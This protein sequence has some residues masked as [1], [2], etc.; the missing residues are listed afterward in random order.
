MAGRVA[1]NKEQSRGLASETRVDR[2]VGKSAGTWSECA[3]RP[4][5]RALLPPPMS[6]PLPS[7]TTSRAAQ[8]TFNATASRRGRRVSTSARR[9]TAGPG[10]APPLSRV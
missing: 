1:V 3:L 6:R 9:Q 4:Q 8:N 10:P 5:P 7:E 2:T